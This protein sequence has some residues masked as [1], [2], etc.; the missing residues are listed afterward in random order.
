MEKTAVEW[1][2]IQIGILISKFF[3]NEISKAD[4]HY[5]R[6]DIEKQAKEREIQ[7]IK[8]AYI[9]GQMRNELPKTYIKETYGKESND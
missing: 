8:K 7:N 5:K 6:L 4:L 9:A 3:N 2:G 1:Q